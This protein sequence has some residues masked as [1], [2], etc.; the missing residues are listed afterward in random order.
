[1]E[2]VAAHEEDMLK[3]P[4]EVLEQVVELAQRLKAYELEPSEVDLKSISKEIT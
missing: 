3:P 1:M 2:V 4:R